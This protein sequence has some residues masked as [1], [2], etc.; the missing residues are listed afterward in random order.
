MIIGRERTNKQW[1]SQTSSTT[2][3]LADEF[4]LFFFRFHFQGR[5]K[6]DMMKNLRLADE[7]LSLRDRVIC[8]VVAFGWWCGCCCFFASHWLLGGGSPSLL[9]SLIS[10][11]MEIV[12]FTLLDSS[13][14]WLML[15]G[16]EELVNDSDSAFKVVEVGGDDE[17]SVACLSISTKSDDGN[18][19]MPGCVEEALVEEDDDDDF[20]F[21]LWKL[22]LVSLKNVLLKGT[23]FI[24]SFLKSCRVH[25][26]NSNDQ[27]RWWWI[28]CN[29]PGWG[30]RRRK[31]ISS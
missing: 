28:I 13:F 29:I 8:L 20:F 25:S 18:A 23:F 4:S 17:E 24:Q 16:P 30:K 5:S 27:W 1:W 6:R 10:Q 7:E 21:F 31:C 26:L 14:G 12:P 2:L 9:P 22:I 19:L 3:P 11:D 15:F